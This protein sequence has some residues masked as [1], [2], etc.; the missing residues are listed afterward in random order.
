MIDTKKFCDNV[1]L[2]LKEIRNLH[3]HVP[4]KAMT[5]AAD[6]DEIEQYRT[7]GMSTSEC[8]DLLISLAQL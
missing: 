1:L 3:V 2:E 5:M 8:A 4:Q 6:M 7:N